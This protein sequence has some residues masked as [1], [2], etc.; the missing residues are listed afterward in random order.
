MFLFIQVRSQSVVVV[1][2]ICAMECRHIRISCFGMS[3]SR[4]MEYQEV[5]ADAALVILGKKRKWGSSVPGHRM[6][7]H[8]RS[9]VDKDL[10]KNYFVER[11]LYNEDRLRR[12]FMHY[13]NLF[14]CTM[15]F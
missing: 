5:E 8:D 13:F 15:Q 1:L 14:C 7:H 9:G 12:R 10:M 2:L 11:P 4:S 3:G 6:Y